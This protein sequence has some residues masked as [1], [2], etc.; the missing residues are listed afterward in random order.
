MTQKIYKHLEEVYKQLSSVGGQFFFSPG[1]VNLIGEHTDYNG[2]HVFPAAIT[3]GTYGLIGLREDR[4]IKCYS[5][6]FQDQ[7]VVEFSL[8]QLGYRA[9]HAWANY[10]KGVVK[11]LNEEQEFVD[12]GFNLVVY[13]NI[14]NGAGLSSSASLE[15]LVAYA[16]N[17]LFDG[18][19]RRQELARIGQS[20]ENYFVGV[21]SGIMDQFAVAMGQVNQ[22]IFLDVNT[23]NYELIP[24]DF[25]DYKI[26]IMNT[27]KRREL[28]DSKYNQRRAECEAAL[29]ALQEALAIDSLGELTSDDLESHKGL[30]QDPTLL[31]RARHAVSENGR[32]LLAKEALTTGDLVTFGQLLNASHQSLKNDYEV[33]GV[34]LDTLA[35]TA[36]K[37]SGVLGARMTGAGMGGCAI[38]LVHK[39]SVEDVI[40]AVQEVY[41][42]V[43]GYE[44][45]FF[46]AEVGDGVKQVSQ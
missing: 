11:F 19:L 42:Q 34:E 41:T 38:A 12:R 40:K 3:L 26:L 30:L 6:N 43:T 32:T 20:V 45:G 37:Q 39:D 46:L 14:P 2:G 4:K 28:V 7:G 17:E 23:M 33:T 13:G 9:N 44:A 35:E 16:L 31:K 24:A 21:N 15:L 1:R 8:D 36:Q 25:G 10:V 18:E 29:L 5:L 27:N 22:A